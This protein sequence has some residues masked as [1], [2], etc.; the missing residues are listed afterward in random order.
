[1]LPSGGTAAPKRLGRYAVVAPLGK[2]GMASVL[3]GRSAG[4]AGF[5]KSVALKVLHANYAADSELLAQFIEEAKIAALI[6]H[7][8]V[9]SV[10][11]V[12]EEDGVVFLV[13]DYVDGGSLASLYRAARERG[14]GLP[15]SV[16]FRILCDALAGLHAAH[17][18]RDETGAALG[19]VHRD[20]SPQNILVGRSG[21]AQLTDFGVAKILTAP[22][23]TRSGVIK[24]KVR[25][26]SPE[27]VR[28]DPVDR[29]CDVWAAG[30][31]LWETLSGKRLYGNKDDV[32][33]LVDIA[34]KA[35]P[36][37]AEVKPNI[38]AELEAV[39]MSALH[40]SVE[41]RCPDAET[42]RRGL[43]HAA[44]AIADVSEVA[45]Q[46]RL[47]LPQS[48][49]SA[50]SV[51]TEPSHSPAPRGETVHTDT[52]SL[53]TLSKAPRKRSK[54][55]L[56]AFFALAAIAATAV[57]LRERA[58]EP[59]IAEPPAAATP[60][61]SPAPV[62]ATQPSAASPAEPKARSVELT[63]SEP[64]AALRVDGR[65]VDVSAPGPAQRVELPADAKTVRVEAE[66]R[67]GRIARYAGDVKDSI[68]LRF[69]AAR[70]RVA[71]PAA[72]PKKPK[73]E[74]SNPDSLPPSPYP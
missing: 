61:T 33:T 11:E 40:R 3:L 58:R 13:M 25:Y 47:F 71:A 30:V 67:D 66:T 53:E 39:V 21:V 19:V 51:E 4:P 73:P 54:K 18:L 14:V 44:G 24:G 74:P 64:I 38:P 36:R 7:S 1:V 59:A 31:I 5:S 52:I 15:Q 8:N 57:V 56:V 12:G 28:G 29:R 46:V 42:L 69:P 20:F 2:G 65:S 72:R 50:P 10:H 32:A 26:M 55:P 68:E 45:E 62:L 63:G 60:A 16:F 22:G 70:P 43:I 37:L 9:V 6:R 34:T 17:E 48:P 23:R 35:P 49:V 41:E 27:Q